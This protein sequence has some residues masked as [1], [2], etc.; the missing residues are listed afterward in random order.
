MVC[1]A[2]AVPEQV[3]EKFRA[4][5]RWRK[6]VATE[7]RG[8]LQ[9]HESRVHHDTS[10]GAPGEGECRDTGS[11]ATKRMR[12]FEALHDG[13][14]HQQLD[15]IHPMPAP[16]DPAPPPSPRSAPPEQTKACPNPQDIA[17]AVLRCT[18]YY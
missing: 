6:L 14:P 12:Q 7:A 3:Q 10:W 1:T 9:H 8:I 5:E 16:A 15:W 4:E 18:E 13:K 17:K 11:L 2:K